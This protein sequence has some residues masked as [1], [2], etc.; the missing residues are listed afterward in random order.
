[1]LPNC[2]PEAYLGTEPHGVPGR[3]LTT[4]WAGTINSHRGDLRTIRGLLGDTLNEAGSR[5]VTIGGPGAVSE[6]DPGAEVRRT[7]ELGW[8]PMCDLPAATACF[9]VGLAPLKDNP[10]NKA[11]SWLKVLEY[12][13]LG[14]PWIGADTPQYRQLQGGGLIARHPSDWRRHL[15][16]LLGSEDMRQA[17]AAVGRRNAGAWTVEAN[18]ERWLAA[19]SDAAAR[20]RGRMALDG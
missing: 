3:E 9:D 20:R 16:A 8:L 5:L 13:A 18:A 12:S 7:L 6:L 4:G 15:G 10:F 2:V 17:L 1:V 19:W 14:V 11:K